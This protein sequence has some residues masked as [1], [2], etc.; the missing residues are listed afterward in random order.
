MRP[1]G[2]GFIVRDDRF[3]LVT[4]A[5]PVRITPES[6]PP[7]FASYERVLSKKQLFVSL[8]DMRPCEHIPDANVR[9]VIA[10]WGV[11]IA[12]ERALYVI[13][14]AFVVTNPLVRAA[15]TAVHFLAPPRQPTIA[16]RTESEASAFLEQKLAERGLTPG[17]RTASAED[18]AG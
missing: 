13:G 11:R 10:D 2:E 8:V 15:L 12:D 16:V 18:A 5:Y 14:V 9:K 6:L 4:T 3:P 17:P 1:V 7:Y